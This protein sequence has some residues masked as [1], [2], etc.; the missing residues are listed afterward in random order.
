MRRGSAQRP[1]AT[2]PAIIGFTPNPWSN[3]WSS[4]A[5]IMSGLADRGWPMLYS[6]GASTVWDVGRPDWKELPWFNAITVSGSMRVDRPGRL[7][8]RWPSHPRCDR[9]AL[10]VHAAHLRRTFRERADEAPIALLFHPMFWPYVAHLRPRL[11]IY[12]AYDAHS[13]A[14]GWNDVLAR[15]EATLARNA[16]LVLA[17]SEGMLERLPAGASRRG[18]VLPTGVDVEPFEAASTERCPEDLARIPRPRIG[19]TG[20]INQ[21]LDYRL[22]LD[23]ATRKPEWQWCFVGAIGADDDGRFAADRDAESLWT[24][25]RALPNVHVLGPKPR[26]DVPR[27]LMHM[28]VNAMCYRTDDTGWWR[29]IFPLKSMEYLAAARPVVSTPVKSML[30]Y[31]DSIAIAAT[32]DDWVDAIGRALAGAGVGT[33]ESRRATA[34]ANA[35]DLRIDRLSEWIIESLHGPRRIEAVT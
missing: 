15:Y 25:C 3:G 12:Y 6:S 20:R 2:R 14:P 30:R 1:A 11:L 34:R 17:Y 33:P 21:K 29:A 9:I 28:D 19:Y 35:W 13:L 8:V 31:D 18:R 4:R 5:R 16:D 26:D 32:A 27:Y 22:V 24:R 10:A 7:V 23:I